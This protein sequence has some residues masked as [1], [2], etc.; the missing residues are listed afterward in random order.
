VDGHASRTHL[1]DDNKAAQLIVKNLAQIN[2]LVLSGVI[3][4]KASAKFMP[5]RNLCSVR[6]DNNVCLEKIHALTK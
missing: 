4:A 3:Y 2:F 1:V 5:W 6:I